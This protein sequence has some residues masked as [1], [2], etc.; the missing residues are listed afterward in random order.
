MGRCYYKILGVSVRATEDQIR[1]S[2]RVLA[3]RWHPDKNQ[4]NPA[5]SA[6]FREVLEAYETLIDGSKRDRYDRIRGLGRKER[7]RPE[8]S[9]A[10]NDRPPAASSFED[11]VEELFGVRPEPRRELDRRYDL[12]FDLQ[13][14]RAALRDGT[15]E[16]I[17]FGRSVL[18]PEC[19][20][21]RRRKGSLMCGR[22]GGTG[23]V[24]EI[25]SMKI[26]IPPSMEHGSRLRLRGWGDC[27]KPGQPPG[28]LV[29]LL[30]VGE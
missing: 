23:E 8:R 9:S 24:E 29:I 28:D 13:V 27:L 17:A 4:G 11:I 5:A 15:E 30:H 19:A 6:R 1:Q 10:F 3:L 26:T 21:A 16:E 2:F 20:G 18:C 12:R 22:C 25:C 7:R 14:R